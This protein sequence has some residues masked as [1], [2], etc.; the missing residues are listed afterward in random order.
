MTAK[1]HRVRLNAAPARVGWPLRHEY[2]RN[3]V[4]NWLMLVTPLEGSGGWKWQNAA[5]GA[6][7]G[8]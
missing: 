7:G 2:Q 6:G 4:S 8:R 3:G 5:P 1:K